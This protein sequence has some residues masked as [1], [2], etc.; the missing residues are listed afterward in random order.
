MTFLY[1]HAF[2]L[3]LKAYLRGNGSDLAELKKL[4]HRVS[5]AADLAVGRGL[6]LRNG[7]ADILSHIQDTDAAIEARY[8]TTG[9]KET[10]T[11]D[12]FS[13]VGRYLDETVCAALARLGQPV[14][15][16]RFEPV[17]PKRDGPALSEDTVRVLAYLF[18]DTGELKGSD[19]WPSAWVW[20]TV[21]RSIT[22]TALRRGNWQA[23]AHI[24]RAIRFGRLH[25]R[26]GVT[27]L[28]TN[29]IGD[30]TRHKRDMT[31]ITGS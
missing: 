27:S 31:T 9:F 2:E 12:A 8:I 24:G 13:E 10:P 26:E 1:C 30:G 28:K 14:R 19:L 25:Q 3:Y 29:F 6:S 7:V 17:E 20:S 22:S 18:S 11:N 16:E 4:S 21:L 23:S 5:A 15:M